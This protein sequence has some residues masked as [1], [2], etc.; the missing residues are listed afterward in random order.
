[1]VN[2]MLDLRIVIRPIIKV[3][4]GLLL[5]HGQANL[6]VLL[7]ESFRMLKLTNQIID[8]TI[9]VEVCYEDRMLVFH[10]L[11]VSHKERHLLKDYIVNRN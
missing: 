10:N 9:Y 3:V 2:I 4:H 7:Q 5:Y 11:I 8:T 6:K 1:M